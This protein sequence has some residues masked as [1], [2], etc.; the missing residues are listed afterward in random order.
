MVATAD[1]RETPL[2]P[3]HKALG[4]RMVEFGGWNMPVSYTSILEEHKA[5]REKA[6]LFDISHMG[7]VF[8][9]GT[10]SE[11]WLNTLLTNDI[12]R[13]SPGH[14][15]YTLMLNDA[16]G[17]VDDLIIYRLE[18]QRY[19]LLVNASRIEDDYNWL[20]RKKNANVQIENL[21]HQFGG[22]ALQGPEAEV[23]F[24]K[25]FENEMRP[26]KRNQLLLTPFLAE[27]VIV[28]RTGYTGEDGFE[29]FCS[30]ETL[31]SLWSK[32]LEEG[33][34][35]GLLPA[36]LG[37]RDTLR[38]EACYPLYGHELD[39]GISPLEAGLQSFVSFDKPE[40]F[41]GI[42][43]LR[44][45]KLEGTSRKSVALEV[46][47][48]GAPPRAQYPLLKKGKQI[49]EVTSGSHSPTLKKGIALALIE[50]AHA[51]IGTQL[52]MIV[53]E[54]PVTVQIVKKPFYQ[55]R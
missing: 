46:I 25:V 34:N 52:E 13:I 23:I 32:L 9:S 7:Q 39:S 30:H 10:G 12:R 4:A 43:T 42:E 2:S 3:A 44:K 19:L 38:L 33:K 37:A 31:I 50:T 40:K 53:R 47:G 27:D 5:V 45:Q 21:S 8:V 16:G 20:N 14:G 18:E 54:Q 55:K 51:E 29:F 22:L 1:L 28:T 35:H 49:G 24:H 41:I 6:G 48:V 11:A 15:Q 26:I 36:G 17:T